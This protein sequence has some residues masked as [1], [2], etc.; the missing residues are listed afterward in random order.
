M[1]KFL[2][3]LLENPRTSL[4]WT[5]L[6]GTHRVLYHITTTHHDGAHHSYLVVENANGNWSVFRHTHE[7][8]LT[9]LID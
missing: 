5:E 6:L 4:D 7:N 3:S 2:Q 8:P 9:G 1:D